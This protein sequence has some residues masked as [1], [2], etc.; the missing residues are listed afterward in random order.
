MM[1]T[2]A[3]C[4]FVLIIIDQTRRSSSFDKPN[5]FIG[6]TDFD[7][8]ENVHL[9]QRIS[10]VKDTQKLSLGTLSLKHLT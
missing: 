6:L 2:V 3:K 9:R 4:I 7:F 5:I 10:V 8:L 1:L